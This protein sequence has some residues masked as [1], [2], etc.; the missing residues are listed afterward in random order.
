MLL[1][2]ED[3]HADPL[4]SSPAEKATSA[5][6][7]TFTTALVLNVVIAAIEIGAFTLI[8]RR[9]RSIYEP[10]TYIPRDEKYDQICSLSS[11]LAAGS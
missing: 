2:V 10:R 4:L 7:E 5:S 3:L 11:Q 8:R 6:T 9:F 1:A